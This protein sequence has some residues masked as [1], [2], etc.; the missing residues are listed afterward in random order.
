MI[1][2]SPNEKVEIV[3]DKEVLNEQFR[4]LKK[5][6]WQALI[7]NC[8]MPEEDAIEGNPWSPDCQ[9]E[10]TGRQYFG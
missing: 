10:T 1:F 6:F 5:T 4:R 3:S 8:G 9:T 7:H 2:A